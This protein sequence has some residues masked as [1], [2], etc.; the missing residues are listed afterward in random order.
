MGGCGSK[1][2]A[3]KRN[4]QIGRDQKRN[5][6]AEKS[7]LKLLLLGAGESGKSTLFKQMRLLYSQEKGFNEQDKLKYKNA[8]YANIFL[9]MMQICTYIEKE[10]GGYD[11]GD[12]QVAATSFMR[13]F[14]EAKQKHNQDKKERDK[15]KSIVVLTPESAE[16][17]SVLWQDPKTQELWKNREVLQ[18]QDSLEYFM[19]PDNLDRICRGTYEPT[20][21][22][23]LRTRIRTSGLVAE[24]FSISGANLEMYDV[25]GQ[26]SERQKWRQYFDGVTGVIF[27]AAISEYNQ[28]MFENNDI[29]RQEDA[30]QLFG[31][32]LHNDNWKD[33]PFILFLNKTDLF[34]KK[35]VDVPFRVTTGDEQRNVDFAGPYIDPGKEYSI[36]GSDPDF[37]GCYVA[38]CNYLQALYEGQNNNFAERNAAIYTRL[39]NSTDTKLMA[40]IMDSC[41]DIILKGNLMIGGWI[42]T[43][44]QQFQQPQ[45]LPVGAK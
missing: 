16:E 8:L 32:Q 39:T 15:S 42:G 21:D 29:S 9:D 1:G 28:K 22:D 31:E 40:H 43:E 44:Q 25:G 4:R 20:N 17:I 10:E 19:I 13:R 45:D 37:E 33:T 36:D 5:K 30:V 41:K 6:A 18:V 12:S 38:A 11:S 34:R 26:Q 14:N 7:K 3:A 2:E 27:V 24:E 35:L 23:I